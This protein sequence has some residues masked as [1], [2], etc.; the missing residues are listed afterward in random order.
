MEVRLEHLTKIFPSRDKKGSEVVAVNDF[1]FTIPEGTQSGTTFTVRG[2]G[3]LI[4]RSQNKRG[5]LVFVVNVE[6]PKGLNEKQREAMRAFADSCGEG[7][8]SKR[9]G[10]FKRIFDKK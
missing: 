6:I 2:K 7:N 1:D 10:F 4:P 9:S 8:Y 5:D 3:I